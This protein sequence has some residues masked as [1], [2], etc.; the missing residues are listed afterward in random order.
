MQTYRCKLKKSK[1]NLLK[2]IMQ[3]IFHENFWRA[4]I[5]N[6]FFSN[7]LTKFLVL[8]YSCSIS[9]DHIILAT[10]KIALL[11]IV[12]HFFESFVHK[13]FVVQR[14]EIV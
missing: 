1:Q 2:N 9:R 4:F 10:T 14:V 13:S 7:T 8:L 5:L 6:F 11:L 3:P 12:E